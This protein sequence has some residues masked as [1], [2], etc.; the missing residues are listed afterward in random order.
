MIRPGR[1][2]IVNDASFAQGGATGLALA[3]A[4][5]L[6]ARGLNV[7]LLT[8]DAGDAPELAALGI[9][10]VALGRQRLMASAKSKVIIDALY[11]RDAEKMVGDWIVANDR[12]DFVYHLHGWAQILSPS[13]FKA[14]KPVADRLVMS[15][16]DFF[17]VCPNG[18]YAFLKSG[19]LCTLTPMSLSCVTANCDRRNYGHKL[20]RVARQAVRQA[21]FDFGRFS[22]P[23]L[24]IHESMRPYLARGGI[25]P[26]AIRTVPNP[27][28]PFRAER[29]QA[30][31]NAEFVFIGRLEDGKGPDLAAAA[32]RRAGVTLRIIGDGPMRPM[33]EQTYP[34]VLFSG[35]RSWEEIGPLVARA[36]AL[37]MPSRYPEPYGL[38][39]AEALWSG[40][41]VIAAE[42]AFLAHDIVAHD[43]GLAC[44]PR[45]EQAFADALTRLGD[46]EVVHRMSIN[47]FEKTRGIGQ[48]FDAWI[49]DLIANYAERLDR[50]QVA[51]VAS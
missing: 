18:A 14:L 25:Q 39:A 40:L 44:D 12:P 9:E 13:V 41:P 48:T 50:L 19:A 22:P 1:V 46:D 27:V 2:V 21:V 5:H 33:L 23:V 24:A 34:E 7:T 8:G 36:R 35:R 17:L 29:I 47:A 51:R 28:H 38:V 15:A 45:D 30:E 20:W 43:A 6:R 49:D 4:R 37:V 32:A 16:H 11:N 3:S 26:S 31:Q 42:T 10:I